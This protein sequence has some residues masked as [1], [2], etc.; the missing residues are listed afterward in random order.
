MLV[1]EENMCT[2]CKACIDKC[3]KDAIHIVDSLKAYNAV[4]DTDLCIDCG[5]CHKVC[6]I[7]ENSGFKEPIYWWQGWAEKEVREKSS[8]GGAASAI[9]RSF[10]KS[11][12]TICSCEF[13]DGRFGFSFTNIEGEIKRF[14][15]S[16]YVKSDPEGIYKII[17]GKL[18][19]GEKVLFLGLPCQ[20][21]A[22]KNFVGTKRMKNLHTVDLICHGTPSPKLLEMFLED[23]HL[24]LKKIKD[25]RF[26]K[27]AVF[28]VYQAYEGI[29]PEIV[30]DTYIF[31]FM[32][33]LDYT[34]GCYNCKYARKE[35][36]GDIT[37]GDSWGST[38]PE[39]EQKKGVSL[40]LCQ[41]EKG[42]EMLDASG[43]HLEDVDVELALEN[44]HQLR[45]P[46]VAPKER[47]K[48]FAMIKQT[49][50][51][52]KAIA[53]CYPK[54]YYKQKIKLLLVKL[55]LIGGGIS[56]MDSMLENDGDE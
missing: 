19:L 44:N 18:E 2:G 34:E 45:H 27:K 36:M 20:V 29:V 15:G 35:R 9:M 8:S 53:H 31:S 11:G 41:T 37:L 46:S 51:F 10:V 14:A 6:Q 3:P 17:S 25:I 26:R 13:K 52:N 22:V 47:E 55:H 38:L 54:F 33:C 21:A 23:Y 4:I 28:H 43:L 40:L 56:N 30:Q 42:K 5:T 24:S 48:F 39:E 7:N 1:C 50:S 49:K 12:G 32:H 16:K